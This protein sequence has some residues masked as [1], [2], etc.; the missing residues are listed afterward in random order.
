MSA[1][2]LD[3]MCG[4]VEQLHE[5]MAGKPWEPATTRFRTTADV[6]RARNVAGALR[7]DVL[8]LL[9]SALS[10]LPSKDQPTVADNAAYVAL[11]VAAVLVAAGLVDDARSVVA[12]LRGFPVDGLT[13]QLVAAAAQPAEFRTLMHARWL[14]SQGEFR[15]ATRM[16]KPLSTQTSA[17][18]CQQLALRMLSLPWPLKSAPPMGTLNGFG[19]MLHGKRDPHDDGSYVSTLFATALFIPVFPLAAYR[20]QST[21][22]GSYRFFGKVP[23]GPVAAWFQK[24]VA[25]MALL[26]GAVTGVTVYLQSPTH[27]MSQAVAEA[28]A[29]EQAGDVDEAAHQ[30]TAALVAFGA[31]AATGPVAEAAS[32]L[33]RI[34]TAG[35]LPECQERS[36]NRLRSV[37][38]A[39]R[40]INAEARSAATGTLAQVFHDCAAATHK[41]DPLSERAAELYGVAEQLNAGPVSASA[42]QGRL[43]VR[44]AQA[45]QLGATQPLRALAAHLALGQPEDITAT[46]ALVEPMEAQPLYLAEA[47]SVVR[48]WLLAAQNLP[49]LASLHQ[50]V[51]AALAQGVALAADPERTVVLEAGSAAQLEALLKT[52]PWDQE[53]AVALAA[54]RLDDGDLPGAVR[55]LTQVAPPTLRGLSV[56][57]MLAETMIMENRLGDA[58][59]ALQAMCDEHLPLLVAARERYGA[60]YKIVADMA[61]SDVQNG[62]PDTLFNKQ[63][64]HATQEEA[65]ALA[66]RWVEDRVQKDASLQLLADEGSAHAPVIGAAI[67]LGTVRLRLARE[68]P[69]E[70]RG[71]IF[72]KAERVLLS[73]SDAAQGA[74]SFHLNMGKV[75][76]RLGRAPEG[77]AEFKRITDT[78]DWEGRMDVVRAY[79]ELGMTT[80]A[81]EAAQQLY[82]KAPKNFKEGAAIQM[83]LMARDDQENE[84]WLR[85]GPAAAAFVKVSLLELEARRALRNG[86]L[87]LADTKFAQA[88]KQHQQMGS[89]G[90]NLNNAAL[91]M[92]MRY[93]CTGDLAHLQNA[94]RLLEKAVRREPDHS[95]VIHNLAETLEQASAVRALGGVVHVAQLR[96]SGD[97]AHDVIRALRKG[98]TALSVGRALRKDAASRRADDLRS[99]LGVLRPNDNTAL[100]QQA[101]R[102]IAAKD[103]EGLNALLARVR[104]DP[105]AATPSPPDAKESQMRRE[106]ERVDELTAR[107]KAWHSATTAP[108]APTRAAALLLTGQSQHLLWQ[109]TRNGDHARNAVKALEAAQARWAGLDVHKAL[110]LALVGK[111]VAEVAAEHEVFGS[112]FSA[113][114]K[115]LGV[116][117]A[118]HRLERDHAADFARL[119]QRPE[120]KQ[121]AA[122]LR[123][124]GDA[125]QCSVFSLALA[126]A[127]ADAALRDQCAWLRSDPWVRGRVELE[128]LLDPDDASSALS[129]EI[130]QASP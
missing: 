20:V 122:V 89:S 9:P 29:V 110:A 23:L 18:G 50:S 90:S 24:A 51:T 2:H 48:P 105:P 101:D 91:A 62:T 83:A 104:K 124:D 1:E 78:N 75:H 74:A 130:L 45:S 86:N 88:A 38:S 41:A 35:V 49:A 73:I 72:K 100:Y 128:A 37:V 112:M 61:W 94:A 107:V 57:R 4:R 121:A 43:A 40:R 69:E 54:H 17:P 117:G 111:A 93:Q 108:H 30:Y 77:S 79:R 32:G 127:A 80:E 3:R 123:S 16:A 65:Q 6:D 76:Y 71:E 39:I 44:R 55:M 116:A 33:T 15:S 64:K 53:A 113:L 66:N 85:R 52:H 92:G 13:R 7:R 42:R 10:A 81:R 129:W 27:Q 97:S 84:R 11:E 125:Q 28:R 59:S 70:Q 98:K 46:G 126:H 34:R 12:A 22:A 14:W 68:V 99:Q 114:E 67:T 19:A 58:D 106:L 115:T 103:Q 56:R 31:D 119:S 8:A 109:L 120:L 60:R 36:V 26:G 47:R 118:L 21:G 63:L 5:Q 82:D 87:K 95:I 25:V 96:L 102:L